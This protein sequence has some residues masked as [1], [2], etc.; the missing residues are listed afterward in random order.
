MR[1]NS[2][3]NAAS[4]APAGLPLAEPNRYQSGSA[5]PPRSARTP[6]GAR[7][8]PPPRCRTWPRSRG[9]RRPCARV[10]AG[11]RLE[12]VQRAAQLPGLRHRVAE[13]VLPAPGAVAR[14]LRPEGG[15]QQRHHAAPGQARASSRYCVRLEVGSAARTSAR[16]ARRPAARRRWPAARGTPA[17]APRPP[18]SRTPRPAPSPR[19][20]FPSP[21]RAASSGAPR[22]VRE[23]RVQRGPRRWADRP[24]RRP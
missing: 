7:P 9:P 6:W 3:R 13:V 8:P 1:A 23:Q 12:H 17:W 10:H 4:S 5:A 22:V 2:S 19:R 20:A 24:A 21:P 16:T 18:R 11:L 14:L 15:D